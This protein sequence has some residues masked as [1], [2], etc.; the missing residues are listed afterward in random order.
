MIS[1]TDRREEEVSELNSEALSNK[2]SEQ[3]I[4]RENL[5]NESKEMLEKGQINDIES[6]YSLESDDESSKDGT[7]GESSVAVYEPSNEAKKKIQ[8]R[9]MIMENAAATGDP[10]S[11]IANVH[12][13]SS[14][15]ASTP[16]SFKNEII[17]KIADTI[18]DMKIGN[19]RV[20][21]DE[22]RLMNFIKG[23]FSG[24]PSPKTKHEDKMMKR[25]KVIQ[26]TN[27]N[28]IFRRRI[29]KSITAN[30]NFVYKG[31]SK[32]TVC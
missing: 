7:E 23:L 8:E 5:E 21:K 1:D 6:E 9:F 27:I 14:L 16:A 4:L 20:F 26:H 32:F 15:I 29:P 22:K 10:Q 3:D 19:E 2:N 13:L 18:K 25:A 17:I 12:A 28:P 30:G 31:N 24:H 11:V